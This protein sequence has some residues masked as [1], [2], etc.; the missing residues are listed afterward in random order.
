MLLD[1]ENQVEKMGSI[2]FTDD[3]VIKAISEFKENKSAG[4]DEINSTYAINIKEI[5]VE[6]LRIL[7]NKS[8]EENEIPDGRKRANITPIFRKGDKS[9][10][11]NYRP[12]SLTI[13]FCKV[14]EKLIKQNI[15]RHLFL[16]NFHMKT[17]HGFRKGRSCMS[18]LLISQF[19]I[20]NVIDEGGCVDI[21]Y[22]DF[23]K[24]FDK[25]PHRNLIRKV[26]GFGIE[27]KVIGW[28]ENWLGNRTQ[29][30]VING[31][32]SDWKDVKSGVPPGSILG[33]LLF[34]MYIEDID[35][36]LK[37]SKLLKFADDTKV[38]GRVNTKEDAVLIQD[39][40]NS[41]CEWSE[42]NGML[43]LYKTLVRPIV[44]YCT[45]VWRPYLRKDVNKIE[46]V[47][48][49]FTKMIF[50]CRGQNYERRLSTLGLTTLEDRHYRADMIQVFNILN[51]IGDIYPSEMLPLSNRLGRRNSKKLYKRRNLLEITR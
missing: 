19:S 10:V 22:L 38:W 12:V 27:D 28:I 51:N 29:R 3:D 17:Q 2:S 42:K 15:D 24:A 36:V 40:L 39:D 13:L 44:D 16:S 4:L 47:Q 46:K 18:N 49:R 6:P 32:S 50:E 33:P 7:F 43:I 34:T 48:K 25:V 11:S 37:S 31:V 41:L 21:V 1:K 26:K 5:V 14:M 20:M 23:Q 30:V 9:L 8:L 45:P 35:E